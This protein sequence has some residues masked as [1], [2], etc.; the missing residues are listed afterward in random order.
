MR[1]TFG[2]GTSGGVIWG[3]GG[4]S[5]GS[6]EVRVDVQGVI[7]GEVDVRGGSFG[8]RVDIQGGSF[9]VSKD[10]QG[11]HLG[12]QGEGAEGPTN[13]PKTRRATAFHMN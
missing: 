5:G 11:G 3:E 9:G 7:W 1:W 12:C 4:R 10:I 6:F 13:G 2:E 8:V